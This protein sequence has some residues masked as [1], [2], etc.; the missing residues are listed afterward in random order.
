[1]TTADVSA[2]LA[3][4]DDAP[5]IVRVQLASWR[6]NGVVPEQEVDALDPA[7]LAERWATLIT[8]PQDARLRVLVGL[9]R[10]DVRGFA[11]VHPSYDPDS[12]QVTDGEIGELVVDPAHQRAG[13]GSRLLQAA[14]DTLVADKFTRGRWWVGTTD[15]A[16]RAF[17]TES[18]WEPDGAHRELAGDSGGTVKQIR[19]HT[20]LA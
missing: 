5:A 8:A 1:M 12:D 15:D 13:H 20:T 11:L 2:R 17:V 7:E 18:G 4:P 19:L 10:A 6:A 9:E 16:L 3:W 14:V